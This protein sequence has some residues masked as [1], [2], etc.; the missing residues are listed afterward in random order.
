MLLSFLEY[1]VQVNSE[2]MSLLVKS[3]TL[4]YMVPPTKFTSSHLFSWL[5]MFL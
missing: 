2:E 1:Y 4:L 5:N 3:G